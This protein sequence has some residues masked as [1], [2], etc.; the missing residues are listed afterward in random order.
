MAATNA[1]ASTAMK[2]TYVL[3]SA[4]AIIFLS[5]LLLTNIHP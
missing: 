3:L 4:V 1:R 5:M 2:A